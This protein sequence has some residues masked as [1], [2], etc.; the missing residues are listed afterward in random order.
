ME[1]TRRQFALGA[2]AFA[3]SLGE[4]RVA[5]AAQQSDAAVLDKLLA[6]ELLLALAYRRALGSGLL[7]AATESTVGGLLEH[8]LAHASVLEA[9]LRRLGVAPTHSAA[10]VSGVDPARAALHDQRDALHLLAAAEAAAEAAYFG[11]MSKL[12]DGSLAR[13]AAEIMACEAQH[14]TQISELLHPGD[15]ERA[16]PGAYV[17]GRG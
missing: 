6:L 9:E 1:P 10:A 17:Q 2:A 12:G 4:V 13:T 11:A 15:V 7:T 3:A 16:V 5:V 8:E 14:A